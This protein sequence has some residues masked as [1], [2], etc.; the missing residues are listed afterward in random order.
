M[1]IQGS[2][3]GFS[4]NVESI[5]ISVFTPVVGNTSITEDYFLKLLNVAL[6][7]F[8]ILLLLCNSVHDL[9]VTIFNRLLCNSRHFPL[10]SLRK[11]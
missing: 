3:D 9:F 1:F 4:N 6:K 11:E 7:V 2:F 5:F 8:F 10:T